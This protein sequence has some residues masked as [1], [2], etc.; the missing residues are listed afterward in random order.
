MTS[1][2]PTL[3]ALQSPAARLAYVCY[4]PE[5]VTLGKGSI[6]TPWGPADGGGG[7]C[8]ASFRSKMN[9]H[10]ILHRAEGK[11]KEQGM[12]TGDVEEPKRHVEN[13]D[14]ISTKP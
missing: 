7:R 9:K 6:F 3:Q 4:L 14:R 10:R 8:W 1:P 11:S 5:T 13:T 2:D 12:S